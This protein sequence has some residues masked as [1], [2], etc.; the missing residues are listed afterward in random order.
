MK[1]SMKKI[2]YNYVALCTFSYAA[3]GVLLPLLGQYLTGMGLSGAQIGT[4][5]S[6][7]TAMAIFATAFWGEKYNNRKNKKLMVMWLCFAAASIGGSLVWLHGYWPFLIGFIVLYFFQAPIMGLSDAM[8]IEANQPFSAVR[9]WGCIGFAMAVFIAGRIAEVFGLGIIFAGYTICFIVAAIFVLAIIRTEKRGHGQMAVWQS[10]VTASD[11]EQ[12][13][14]IME[15]LKDHDEIIHGKTRY[16]EVIQNRKLL[17]IIAASFFLLGTNVANNT[18][19]SFLYIECGG[20]I[21]GIGTAFLLM[22]GSETVFM[23]LSP[24][25]SARFTIEKTLLASMFISVLRFGWYSF[26]PPSNW[27]IAMFF[28]QGMVNGII[29]VEFIRYIN[30]TVEKKHLGM[31]ISLYYAVSSLST[32]ICQLIGGLVLDAAGGTGVYLFFAVYNVVGVALYLLFGLHK[33]K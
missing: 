20:S 22:V 14:A 19:F 11:E 3:I 31:A 17:G 21:A 12:S 29:L 23:A 5:T 10:R 25:I 33:S 26:G 4:I 7:G 28:L 30:K 15:E 8:T 13:E 18:Y 27:I 32:I 6:A 9:K 2:Y 24:R 1:S 16:R